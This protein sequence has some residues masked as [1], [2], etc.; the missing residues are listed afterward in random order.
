[1]GAL[2][3]LRAIF[4]VKDRAGPE[5]WAD[6]GSQWTVGIT[7]K[8][9][10]L[11]ISIAGASPV[12]GSNLNNEHEEDSNPPGLGPGNTRSITDMAYPFILNSPDGTTEHT[13]HTEF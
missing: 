8:F 11:L 6:R 1:V 5:G 13:E 4:R 9:R 3:T 7:V 2:P 12:A 10:D